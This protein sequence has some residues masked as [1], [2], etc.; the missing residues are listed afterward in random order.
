MFVIDNDG[1]R[2]AS[3]VFVPLVNVVDL[4]FTPNVPCQ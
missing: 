4:R 3:F 2:L 1:R